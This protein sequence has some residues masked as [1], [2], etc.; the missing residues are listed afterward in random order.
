VRLIVEVS[1]SPP[2]AVPHAQR[3]R[4]AHQTQP[5][6]QELLSVSSRQG[7]PRLHEGD[8]ACPDNR[9][10]VPIEEIAAAAVKCCPD[11]RPAGSGA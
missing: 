11:T 1:S 7:M 3:T 5:R 8:R 2:G 9:P 6:R 4:P 10:M